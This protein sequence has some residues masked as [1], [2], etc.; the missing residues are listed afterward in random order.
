V[1]NGYGL[2]IQGRRLDRLFSASLGEPVPDDQFSAY[3]GTDL[4]RPDGAGGFRDSPYSYGLVNTRTGSYFDGFSRAAKQSEL[5]TVTSGLS[6]SAPDQKAVWINRAYLPDGSETVGA[7]FERELPATMTRYL[8]AGPVQWQGELSEQRTNEW[9]FPEN[10]VTLLGD[11]QEYSAGTTSVDRWNAAVFGPSAKTGWATRSKA[12]LSAYLPLFSDVAGHSG[13]SKTDSAASRLYRAGELVYESAEDGRVDVSDL[14]AEE[15]EFRLEM[16][17]T[18]PSVSGLST[19]IDAEWTFRSAAG[20]Q[21]SG[22][23]LWTVRYRPPVNAENVA[24]RH[25]VMLLPVELVPVPGSPVGKPRSVRIQVSGDDGAHW[26][27]AT[28]RSAGGNRYLAVFPGLAGSHVSLKATMADSAG[29][30]TTQTVIRG[31]QLR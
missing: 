1:G 10:L 12:R 30:T 9:G 28:V 25:A 19:R 13:Y 18:R 15:A 22:L 26:T 16:S 6:A 11:W 8:E 23:P 2:R 31:Y 4:G 21:A 5:A 7:S 27:D 29:N 14:P 3:L 17:A 20:E 24:T